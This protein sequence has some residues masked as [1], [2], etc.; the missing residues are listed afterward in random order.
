MT[1]TQDMKRSVANTWEEGYRNPFVQGLGRG[2]LPQESFRFY[3]LQDY[4]YLAQY[5]KV[6]AL[7]SVSAPDAELQ[8]RCI[9]MQ[10]LIVHTEQSLHEAYMAT[11]GISATDMK[12]TRQS[13][14]NR[15]YTNEM[16]VQAQG[17]DFCA[18]LA[19]ILPCAWTYD[20]YARRLVTAYRK[21]LMANP[22]KPWLDTYTSEEYRSSYQWI[23]ETLNQMGKDRSSRERRHLIGIFGASVRAEVQFWTMAYHRDMGTD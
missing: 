3:L 19:T 12:G 13:Q 16:L 14:A 9:L 8:R 18:F 4:L 23:I 21:G 11:W 6:C 20:D 10:Y 22:Y 15:A 17:G 2:T 7:G 1:I 5:A